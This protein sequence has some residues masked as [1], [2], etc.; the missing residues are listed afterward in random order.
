MSRSFRLTRRPAVGFLVAAIFFGS[1][2]AS[3][4]ANVSAR[5]SQ[6]GSSA[7]LRTATTTDAL[8]VTA[9]ET[10]LFVPD[11]LSVQP[12]DLVQLVVTQMADF[13][14]TFVLSS[15]AGDTL[16]PALTNAQLVA[17]FHTHPPLVN[18]TLGSTPGTKFYANFTAPAAGSYE[19]VCLIE[20]HLAQGMHGQLVSSTSGGSNGGNSSNTTLL[21]IGAGVVILVALVV[22]VVLLRRR[23]KPPAT[24]PPPA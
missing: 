23:P 10:V 21:I 15:V 7:N 13:D 12:G 5:S 16:N 3:S 20:G 6:S 22:A 19:Y 1:L 24:V 8:A 11:T 14:H 2:L 18:L 4:A 9:T 17:Y